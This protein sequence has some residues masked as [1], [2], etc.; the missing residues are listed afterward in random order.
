MY[1]P[2]GR[3]VIFY[4][5]N[6][7]VHSHANFIKINYSVPLFLC[8][9]QHHL[10]W[11]MKYRDHDRRRFDLILFWM[12]EL[13]SRPWCLW[14]KIAPNTA[15]EILIFFVNILIQ[16]EKVIIIPRF[17]PAEKISI[18]FHSIPGEKNSWKTTSFLSLTLP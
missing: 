16:G 3:N 18:N 4:F 8:C 5:K 12:F 10:K 17:S 6:K 13:Q 9:F 1:W 2:N 7:Y 11:N 14:T 15:L